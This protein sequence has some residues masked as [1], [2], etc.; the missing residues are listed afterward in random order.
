MT[1]D[2]HDAL[3]GYSRQQVLH[4]GCRECEARAASA[5]HGISKLDKHRFASAWARAAEW[6]QKGLPDVASAEVP[7]LR[8]LWSVQLALHSWGLPVGALPADLTERQ[9]S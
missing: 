3:P 2:Y 5:D 8:V 7:M 1:H 6:N 4:D 9:G